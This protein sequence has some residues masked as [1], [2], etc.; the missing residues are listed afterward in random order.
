M[1]RHLYF[2]EQYLYLLVF[3][4]NPSLYLKKEHVLFTKDLILEVT[5]VCHVWKSLI[6][7]TGFIYCFIIY[8]LLKTMYI[9]HENNEMEHSYSLT[10][11]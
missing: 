9:K 7:N 5:H 4:I 8:L 6:L 10:I 2:E 11:V 3:K 1:L